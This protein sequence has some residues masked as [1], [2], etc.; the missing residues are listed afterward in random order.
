VGLED[1][2]RLLQEGRV[3]DGYARKVKIMRKRREKKRKMRKRK[4]SGDDPADGDWLPHRAEGRVE[5]EEEASTNGKVRGKVGVKG[6]EVGFKRCK[7]E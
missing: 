3:T 5:G 4:M 7:V 1:Y 6:K 2:V